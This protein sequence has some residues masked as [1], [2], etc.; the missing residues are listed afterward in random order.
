VVDLGFEGA[1]FY[2]LH[3]VGEFLLVDGQLFVL[4][5]FLLF[6][7]G[8]VLSSELL[9]YEGS[10]TILRLTGLIFG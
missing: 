3:F 4:L 8:A 9:F 7:F 2:L 6:G 5:L 1:F 10:T